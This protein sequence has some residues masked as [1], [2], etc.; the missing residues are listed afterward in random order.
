MT[1]T[2]THRAID[3]VWRIESARLIAGLARLVGDVGQAEDLA[4][5]ALVAALE[6]WPTTGVPDNPGA[7][8]MT[9]ARHRA[10][11]LLRRRS[12]L[13]RKHQLLGHELAERQ[14]QE[15]PALEAALDNPVG[16]DLL[17]LIFIACHP[18]LS[19][20]ARVAL[21][22]RLVGGLTT[23]EIARAFLV[24]E[25]TVAQRI[26][27]AKRTL[28][29]A[30]VTFELPPETELAGRLES[31]LE[32]IYLIF[33]EGYAATA[34]DDWLRPALCEDALRLG[35]ILAG[36]APDVSAV[37]GLVALMEIQAS[38]SR[39]RVGPG[40]EPILLPDQDRS[41]WDQ[42]LI[43][44]GLAALARAE[45]LGGLSGAYAIQAA[46]AACHARARTAEE[47]DWTRIVALYDALLRLIP[48]PV[49]A[50]NRAV[51]VA[52]AS[53]P[54]AGLALVDALADEPALRGYHL[55]P[56]ARGE[57]LARLGRDDEARAEFARAAEMTRNNRQRD[58]L[59][60][61]ATRPG[62]TSL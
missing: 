48:S 4:Q 52:M 61:R 37:H 45:A 51:A 42:L 14:E 49:V 40:G 19:T 58:L 44:R 13:D 7:W 25:P 54:E 1:A 9:T 50:L 8:L 21:T 11:D 20:D 60:A 12:M 34:G 10:V 38:R 5:D 27:R 35:R 22:L 23:P 18:I 29:D 56:S 57:L 26:V 28:A 3:A 36:L 33:N 15:V 30:K 62:A 53:G 16:D 55:L 47:T 6:R 39:A 59:L 41:R 43:R 31:V 32:V 2:D 46:I 17:R 24:P